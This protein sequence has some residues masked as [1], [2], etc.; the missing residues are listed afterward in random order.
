MR[1]CETTRAEKELTA[2]KLKTAAVTQY[3]SVTASFEDMYDQ[4]HCALSP[5]PYT[6]ASQE[7]TCCRA[8]AAGLRLR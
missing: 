1:D 6:T 8:G 3:R 7:R 2:P 5:L 4:V